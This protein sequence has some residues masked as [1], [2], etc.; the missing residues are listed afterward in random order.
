M[1]DR[2][3]EIAREIGGDALVRFFDDVQTEQRKRWNA[4]DWRAQPVADADRTNWRDVAAAL[5][6]YGR[7]CL[8]M[9]DAGLAEK[10]N[11]VQTRAAEKEQQGFVVSKPIQEETVPSEVQIR[12]DRDEWDRS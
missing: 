3:D 5:R 11:D 12:R 8:N 10:W 2:A 6:S 9:R 1:D 4:P 7:E